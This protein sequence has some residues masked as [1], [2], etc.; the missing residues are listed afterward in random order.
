MV[1]I[2]QW[3]LIVIGTLAFGAALVLWYV[4]RLISVSEEKTERLRIAARRRV[5]RWPDWAP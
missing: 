5:H 2:L 4:I 3:L 1:E